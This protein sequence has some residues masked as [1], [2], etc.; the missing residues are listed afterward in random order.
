MSH[1]QF[2]LSDYANAERDDAE[3]DNDL[4]DVAIALCNANDDAERD[5]AERDDA[6]RDNQLFDNARLQAL[7]DASERASVIETTDALADY[8]A[9]LSAAIDARSSYELAKNAENDS[10]QSKLKSFKASVSHARIAEIMMNANVNANLINRNERV[11]ARFNEK[12]FVKVIN[13]ARAIA[14]VE[15]LNVYTRAILASVKCFEDN[16]MLMTERETKDSCSVS[17]RLSETTRNS[18]LIKVAK[19][20]DASTMSTQASSTNNALQAFN[21]IVETRDAAN[22][23]C[24]KLNRESVAT[25]ALLALI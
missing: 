12:A 20:Y 10:M 17:S 24:F 6:E 11:N 2:S 1:K 14:N 19:H 18:A 7:I 13:I 8:S 16:D 21:V 25:Q 9:T 22:N 15:S 5:D 23:V 4:F 3:R